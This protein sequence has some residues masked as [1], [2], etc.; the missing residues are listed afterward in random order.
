MYTVSREALEDACYDADLDPDSAIRADYSG[1]AM[2]GATC[3]GLVHDGQGEL[4][5]FVIA[6]V[7]YD[8]DAADWLSSTRSDSMGLSQIT[9]WPRVTV[10]DE[11]TVV[12]EAQRQ[13]AERS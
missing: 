5:K 9:Y 6:L 13:D 3:L 11:E 2:Y 4:I 8:E 7:Q 1:R 12:D 10:A